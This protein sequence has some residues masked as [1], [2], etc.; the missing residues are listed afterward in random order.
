M[1]LVMDIAGIKI[2]TVPTGTLIV[3]L[4]CRAPIRLPENVVV[5]VVIVTK[6]EGV[7]THR[8]HP[9]QAVCSYYRVT[10]PYYPKS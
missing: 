3:I 1:A 9:C 5:D 4:Y 10:V 8:Y 2:I 6:R 7:L